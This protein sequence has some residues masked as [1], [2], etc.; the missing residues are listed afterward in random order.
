MKTVLF[1]ALLPLFLLTGCVSG[2]PAREPG[3]WTQHVHDQ[4][5]EI[6]SDAGMFYGS[7]DSNRSATLEDGDA[8][9]FKWSCDING[10]P[11][12]SLHVR[13]DGTGYAVSYETYID[14]AIIRAAQ[15]KL[16]F[17]LTAAENTELRKLVRDSGALTLRAS[18]GGGGERTW[19]LGMRAGET[20]V[21]I[22]MNGG[23]PDEAKRVVQGAWDLIVKP[24]AEDFRKAERYNPEDWQ[25][26]PEFAPLR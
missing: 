14:G 7:G 12:W 13:P 6:E 18:F 3:W 25:N 16:D 10:A 21:G 9:E 11:T 20:L 8:L 1:A 26:A 22:K 24:R 5:P 15:R 4:R 23:F 17:K 2:P 19:L